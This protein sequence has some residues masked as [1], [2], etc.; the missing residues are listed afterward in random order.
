[1]AGAGI[2]WVRD[3]PAPEP[4]GRGVHPRRDDALADRCR[5]GERDPRCLRLLPREPCEGVPRGSRAVGEGGARRCDHARQRAGRARGARGHRRPGPHRRARSSRP[6][7]VERRALRPDRQGDGHPPGARSRGPGDHAPGPRPA[8]R[9]DRPRRPR[10]ADRLRARAAA[11]DERLLAHRGVAEREL[12]ADHAALRSRRG[13]HGRSQRLPGARPPHL[14]LPARQP[15]DPRRPPV[16]GEVGARALHGGEP[17]R[18]V[19]RSRSRCSRSRCRSP[20]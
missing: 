20:R 7:H 9:G 17:R 15:R 16:D 1:M 18:P 13:R 19:T 10:G 5:H 11:S 14:G 4:R 6:E 2:G 3:R 8:R 12:R